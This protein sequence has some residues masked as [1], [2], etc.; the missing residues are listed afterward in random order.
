MFTLFF[1]FKEG[2]SNGLFLF[3]LT[4]HFSLISSTVKY[5]QGNFMIMQLVLPIQWI[6]FRGKL[7]YYLLIQ[8]P[9]MI[10]M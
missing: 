9:N 10:C 2:G 7:L 1:T 4:V 8:T 6:Q 3:F 5:I